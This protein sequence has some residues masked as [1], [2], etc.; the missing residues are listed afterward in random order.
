MPVQF[1]EIKEMLEGQHLEVKSSLKKVNKSHEELD[2]RIGQIQKNLDDQG[3]E[4]SETKEAFQ[5]TVET[6]ERIETDLDAAVEKFQNLNQLGTAVKKSVG[7]AAADNIKLLKGYD[8][9]KITLLEHDYLEAKAITGAADSAGVLIEPYLAP[10]VM[11]PDQPLTIR[12]LLSAVSISSDSIKWWQ[13]DTFTNN[14]APQTAQLAEKAQSDLT[15]TE[16]N[17]SV[18]TIA[19]WIKASN[20]VL[21]D[22]PMLQSKIDG[23][24]RTGLKL[25]EEGQLL[26]GDGTGANLD[27]LIPNSTSYDAATYGK[28]GDTA[29]DQ[30][31]RSILQT[32]MAQYITTAM[33]LSPV[34]WCDIEL[35]KT[36][37]N[38]YLFTNPVEGSTPRLWGKRIVESMSMSA[39]QYVLGGFNMAATLYDREKISVKISTENDKNFIQNAVTILCEERLAFTVEHPLGFTKGALPA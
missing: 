3:S 10:G 1:E 15:F 16:K 17:S 39:K 19:H 21:S 33:V 4:F 14:A 12:D 29:I 25:K 32:M 13:E 8:G 11:N 34:D 27:G 38:A 30:L 9:G 37:D 28:T 18:Q 7:Q 23:K 26:F 5:K 31:R 22:A 35:Q 2:G 36:D 24:L 6:V 20:Q